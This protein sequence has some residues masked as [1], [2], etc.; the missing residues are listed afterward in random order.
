M[1]RIA[2]QA[3]DPPS[4]PGAF[5]HPADLFSLALLRRERV[6]VRDVFRREIQSTTTDL[7]NSPALRS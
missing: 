4:P 2:L 5:T 7:L 3:G 6:R 1:L